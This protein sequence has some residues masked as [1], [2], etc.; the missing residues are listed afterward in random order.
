M[1]NIAFL[2]VAHIHT[3]GFIGAIKRR[4]EALKVKTVWDPDTARAKK[5]A[6]E[7]SAAVTSDFKQILADPS[8]DAL[9]VC[10]ETDLHEQ[11][12][13][14]AAASRKPIFVEK[15]LGMTARDAYAMADAIEKAGS[16]FTTG[17]FMRGD[18]KH[19]FLKQH[20][21]QGSFGKITR[22]RG[23]NCHSG[24]LGGWFDT[25]WRWMADPTRSGCGAFGDLGTHSLD[26]MLW[27]M[28]D[29]EAATAM[30]D[31]GTKRYANNNT[32]CD[33]TGEGLMRFRNGAIGTLAAAWTDVAN[34]VSLLISGTDGHAAIINGQLHFQSKHLPQFDGT[35]PVRNAE[36]PKAQTAGFDLFLDAIEGKDAPNLVGVREAAYRVAVVEAMYEGA[37]TAR[38][39]TPR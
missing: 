6:D 30:V 15:P 36:L 39:V 26:I 31:P 18:P 29:I 13:I 23:S 28:G 10:S 1:K 32:P 19:L 25:E 3:P 35:A 22:I 33:E 12:V 20:V 8:I 14:P 38:W 7:L 2:G 4:P 21:A 11:L 34:P 5:R 17:Y 24:S 16:V 27:L 9:V 37:R